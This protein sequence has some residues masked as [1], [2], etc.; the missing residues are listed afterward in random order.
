MKKN[1][2]IK[3]KNYIQNEFLNSQNNKKLE[4]SFSNI[5]NHIYKNIN[6]S[7]DVF[8]SFSNKFKFN[9]KTSD[10]I[11]F[12]KFKNVVIVGMGGSIL[13]AEAIYFFLK[14]KIKKKFIFLNNLDENKLDLIKKDKKLNQ[15]LFIVISKSGNTIETL[16][17]ICA[18]KI[19]KKK[20]KNIIVITEKKQNQLYSLVKKMD[21][22]HIEHRKYIGGR[23]S[24]L[25]EV[26]MIPAYLMGLNIN[27]FRK[28]LLKHFKDKNKNYLKDSAIKLVKIIN[29]KKLNNLVF[30]NYSPELDKFLYWCQQLIAESL[31][32]KGKGF[33]PIISPAPKDHH[34]L[35]QLYL[36]GPKDKLFYIF[37]SDIN[38]K[39]KINSKNLDKNFYFLNNSVSKIKTA[40]KNSFVEVLKK[41]RIPFRE[42]TI[43]EFSEQT[44][45]ELFSYFLLETVIVGKLASLNPF[46]QPAIEELKI[47]TKKA[48]L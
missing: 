3:Y 36:D 20:S 7:K 23:Y 31:G 37:S 28:N 18:L 35:L 33:L 17:N 2:K 48:L 44:L 16:T 41:K 8:N 40:Q 10:L 38:K 13:G 14:K 27:N 25:S 46:N 34:S 1:Q 30:F 9:F 6:T 29:N 22:F 45:G 32:K 21:L 19:I 12:R 24:I 5:F 47:N 43:R 26:G 39:V 42:F 11:K 15:I 4:K